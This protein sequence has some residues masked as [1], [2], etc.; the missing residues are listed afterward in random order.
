LGN[1][2]RLFKTNFMSKYYEL[3]QTTLMELEIEGLIEKIKDLEVKLA[4]KELEVKQ[5]RNELKMVNLAM[6]DVS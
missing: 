1:F 5:L 3:K 4:I 6:A 2:G